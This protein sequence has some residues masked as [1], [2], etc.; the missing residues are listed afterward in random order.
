MIATQIIM[1]VAQHL[2][3][4][5]WKLIKQYQ[6]HKIQLLRHFN[7]AFLFILIHVIAVKYIF[8]LGRG[9]HVE[10]MCVCVGKSVWKGEINGFQ[11][12][13]AEIHS[14]DIVKKKLKKCYLPVYLHSL[15]LSQHGAFNFV[16][17]IWSYGIVNLKKNPY[18]VSH[19]VSSL[20]ICN[21]R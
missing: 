1:K 15:K 9:G 4:Q 7:K 5:E 3:P 11:C 12:E 6:L 16:Q 10:I 2:S 14:R 18:H 21:S 19:R 17:L 8:F 13:K 20:L